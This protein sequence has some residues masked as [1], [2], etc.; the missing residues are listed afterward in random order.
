MCL[1]PCPG[2]W[3]NRSLRES[4]VPGLPVRVERAR[5][6]TKGLC[7]IPSSFL[8]PMPWTHP[9]SCNTT[10]WKVLSS[11]GAATERKEAGGGNLTIRRHGTQGAFQ[12]SS[13]PE[14]P[15]PL[16]AVGVVSLQEDPPGS[17]GCGPVQRGA[18]PQALGAGLV[19]WHHL[20]TPLSPD[21]P[22][23]GPRLPGLQARGGSPGHQGLKGMESALSFCTLCFV[24][25]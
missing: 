4:P 23:T 17:G 16:G 21:S 18:G 9:S 11:T 15:H 2:Y 19:G 13:S 25:V 7:P 3:G 6:N 22:P 12:S 8:T 1:R 5:R 10:R 20:P 14:A 24:S